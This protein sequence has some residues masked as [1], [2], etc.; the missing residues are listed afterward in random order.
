MFKKIKQNTI[1]KKSFLRITNFIQRNISL[2]DSYR[3]PIILN[4]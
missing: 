1:G 3:I 4:F 2:N